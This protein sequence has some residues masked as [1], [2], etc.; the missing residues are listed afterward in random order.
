MKTFKLL[1]INGRKSMPNHHVNE[2][3]SDGEK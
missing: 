1:P 3:E 2:Y